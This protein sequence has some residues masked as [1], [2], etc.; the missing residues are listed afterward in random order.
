M[1]KMRRGRVAFLLFA[2]GVF[3]VLFSIAHVWAKSNDDSRIIFQEGEFS[4]GDS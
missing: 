4:M 1:T 2:V 3:F